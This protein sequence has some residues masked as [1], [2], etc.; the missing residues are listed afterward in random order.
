MDHT[1]I[2]LCTLIWY[3]WHLGVEMS[4]IQGGCDTGCF[5]QNVGGE[6]KRL[7]PTPFYLFD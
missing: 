5:I 1:Y 6:T 7:N 4:S 2:M 3:N